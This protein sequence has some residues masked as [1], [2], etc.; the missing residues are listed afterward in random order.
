MIANTLAYTNSWVQYIGQTVEAAAQYTGLQNPKDGSPNL[1]E[2]S[3]SYIETYTGPLEE[4]HAS[5]AVLG[6]TINTKTQPAFDAMKTYTDTAPPA[7]DTDQPLA[8]PLPG[9]VT[10]VTPDEYNLTDG[11]EV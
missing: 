10:P 3:V 11:D 2:R 4:T 5:P 6:T 9:Q 1:I 7:T 8:P